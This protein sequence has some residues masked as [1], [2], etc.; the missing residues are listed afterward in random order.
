[1]LRREESRLSFLSQPEALAAYVE[2]VAV[3]QQPVEDRGGDHRVA[4]EFAPLAEA[5]V[6]SQGDAAAFPSAG[7]GQAYLADTRVKKAVADS[8]S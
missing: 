5:L 3:V 2:H 6:G 7:S 1:M 8:R 4:K